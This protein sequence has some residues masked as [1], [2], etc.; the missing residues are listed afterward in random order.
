MVS[1]YSPSHRSAVFAAGARSV[2]SP[3]TTAPS[4]TSARAEVTR[5]GRR[6]FIVPYI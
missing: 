6:I 5:P 2:T 4:A 1:A 3:P